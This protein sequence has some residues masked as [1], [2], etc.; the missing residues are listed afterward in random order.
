MEVSGWSYLQPDR[1]YM[2]NWEV[3][4][5]TERCT[6]SQRCW[7][8]CAGSKNADQTNGYQKR[9]MVTNTDNLKEEL[10]CQQDELDFRNRFSCFGWTR[11]SEWAR[12]RPW[13]RDNRFTMEE[14]EQL[15]YEKI[16]AF[17]Q[18]QQCWKPSNHSPNEL[19]TAARRFKLKC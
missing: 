17:A 14:M 6:S 19:F 1:S 11:S 3:E 2:Y 8:S 9:E 7:S 13:K 18:L 4:V 5:I 15:H 12:H 10:L 16:Q